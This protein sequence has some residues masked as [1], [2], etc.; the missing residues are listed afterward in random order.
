MVEK[1]PDQ[2]LVAMV[3]P[4][5]SP[6]TPFIRYLKDGT[7]YIDKTENECLIRRSKHYMLVDAS[8]TRKNTKEEILMKCIT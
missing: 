2:P 3:S 1:P 8:F 5:P 4:V 6:T 7:C